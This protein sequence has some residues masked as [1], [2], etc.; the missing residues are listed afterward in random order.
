MEKADKI[1]IE[2]KDLYIVLDYLTNKGMKLNKP[3]T[4]I[5][6]KVNEYKEGILLK[7]LT[8]ELKMNRS[9]I[10]RYVRD[11]IQKGALIEVTKSPKFIKLNKD[12]DSLI[13]LNILECSCGEVHFVPATI[14]YHICKCHRKLPNSK[15]LI[16]ISNHSL[17]KLKRLCKE[18]NKK[19]LNELIK[20]IPDTF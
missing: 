12:I 19:D 17:S 20:S 10:S 14:R 16:S 4:K 1:K 18:R 5:M 8:E 9:N 2:E 13:E 15:Q 11:L 7:S 6:Y 3:E